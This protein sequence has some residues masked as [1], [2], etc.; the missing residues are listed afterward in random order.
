MRTG[1]KVDS[2][3]LDDDAVSTAA[4]QDTIIVLLTN[5]FNRLGTGLLMEN[6]D[7]I[8]MENGDFMVQ[9]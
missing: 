5:I 9:E 8:L 4:K 3:I 1:N 2:N 7:S 6:G